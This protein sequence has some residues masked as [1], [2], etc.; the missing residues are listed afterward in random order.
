MAETLLPNGRKSNVVTTEFFRV[1]REQNGL[2]YRYYEGTWDSLPD[3]AVL[4]PSRSGRLYDVSVD[5]VQHR[6]DEFALRLSGSVSIET[7]GEYR[8]YLS[9]DDGSKL[10][11]DNHEV[12]DNNGLHGP[13]EASGIVRLSP[14]KHPIAI[15]YFERGGGQTLDL[16]VEGPGITKRH[17]PPRMLSP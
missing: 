7:G 8:W 1:D 17:V 10:F 4:T 3:F 9:S 6:E 13:R 16:F 11:I 14:G 15:L 5:A 2:N 12:I